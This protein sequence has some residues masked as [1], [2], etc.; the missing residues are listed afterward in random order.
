MIA[1]I[2]LIHFSANSMVNPIA[3]L[4]SILDGLN[5]VNFFLRGPVV[6][7]FNRWRPNCV[8]VLR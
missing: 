4:N 5:G 6:N 7:T 3:V 8:N 2:T 1:L